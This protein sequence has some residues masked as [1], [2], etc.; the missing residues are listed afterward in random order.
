MLL[1]QAEPLWINKISGPGHSE[2]HGVL[3][4]MLIKPS[5]Q[6]THMNRLSGPELE[7]VPWSL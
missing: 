7:H 4:G 1:R 2:Q 3:V 5:G 6:V